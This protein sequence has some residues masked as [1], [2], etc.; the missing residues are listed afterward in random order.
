M[1][2]QLI[3]SRLKEIAGRRG[4]IVLAQQCGLGVGTIQRLLDGKADPH[5][6]TTL[7]LVRG[8]GLRSVDELL[9]P[10]GTTLVVGSLD[11]A[12]HGSPAAID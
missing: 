2:R 8:L 11:E 3:A 6:S 1:V 10:L 9:A 12:S 7:M 5:L 4:A